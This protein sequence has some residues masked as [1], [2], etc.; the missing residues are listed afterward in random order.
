MSG[1]KSILGGGL[2]P[3]VPH[4]VWESPSPDEELDVELTRQRLSIPLG[5]IQFPPP[6]NEEEFYSLFD[7]AMRALGMQG[8]QK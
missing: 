4:E 6:D 7:E 3:P 8:P 5:G 2:F 1:S